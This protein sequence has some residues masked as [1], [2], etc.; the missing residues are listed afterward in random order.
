MIID[1]VQACTGQQV[2]RYTA[3]HI[4]RKGET[5]TKIEADE[6]WQ[7]L[8]VDYLIRPVSGELTGVGDD[9]LELVT[10]SVKR[11]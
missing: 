6:C 10:V 7:V 2:M 11:I 9:S 8:N 5:I 1:L 4:P 3:E